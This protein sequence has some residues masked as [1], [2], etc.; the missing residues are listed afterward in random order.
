MGEIWKEALGVSGLFQ[1]SGPPIYLERLK[2]STRNLRTADDQPDI[3]NGFIRKLVQVVA[4]YSRH[5]HV[6]LR[7]VC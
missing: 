2:K 7:L 4:S 3:R 5:E 6:P 1:G